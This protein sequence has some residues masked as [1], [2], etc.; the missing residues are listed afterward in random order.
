MRG[1][2]EVVFAINHIDDEFGGVEGDLMTDMVS[3]NGLEQM[4][5]KTI[6]YEKLTRLEKAILEAERLVVLA[7]DIIHQRDIVMK[8]HIMDSV[9]NIISVASTDL[10]QLERECSRNITENRLVE[11][12]EIKVSNSSINI[13]SPIPECE[14]EVR[15]MRAFVDAGEK[16]FN[17]WCSKFNVE[18]VKRKAEIKG[19]IIKAE[20]EL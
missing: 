9:E 13:T 14:G 6:S 19:N 12:K 8:K 2:R 10:L 11:G 16:A 3:L 5:D 1:H 7:R 4:D 20:D 15:K 17:K 18:L